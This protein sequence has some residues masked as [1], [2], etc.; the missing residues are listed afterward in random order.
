MECAGNG[1]AA[2][3][4]AA[5][6]PAVAARGGRERRVDRDAAEAAPR[7]SA[8]ASRS[9][10]PASTAASRTG[11]RRPTSGR[12]R[13]RTRAADDVLLAYELNGAPLPPQHGFP[14]RLLVPGWYGMT[15]VKWLTRIAVLDEPFD[16]LPERHRVPGAP[17]RGRAR[18]RRS[19][20]IEPRAL[21]VPPGVP[22]F[23]T[24]RRFV[25][26][27]PDD[28][29]GPRLVGPRRDRDASRSTPATGW[30][31]AELGA[32]RTAGARVASSGTRRRASTSCAA[33]RPTRPAAGSRTS[34]RGTSAATPTTRSTASPVTV[35]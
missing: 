13:S 25:D 16:R 10:S 31:E 19:T 26:A 9:S 15:S 32:R 33:A 23:M 18:A 8:T 1:R 2:L 3:E 11:S 28:A 4:P 14:L 21:M 22:D 7:R 34:R 35:G 27:R 12:C 5:D 24:R 6:Q 20:R 29:D 30:R 17:A